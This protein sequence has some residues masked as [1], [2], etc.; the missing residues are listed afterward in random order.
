[1]LEAFEHWFGPYPFY[2]DGYKLVEAPYLGMEHQSA[3]TYG[4]GY[5]NGYRGHDLSGTGW[6][7]KFDYIIIHES[8]HEWFANNITYKDYADMWVHES[9]TTYSESLFLDFHYGKE[10]AAEYVIGQRAHIENDR[11]IIGI[12]NVNQTGSGD[13]YYKGANMLHMLRQIVN[14]DEKWRGIL[15]GLNQDFYHQTVTTAQIENYLTAQIGR[16]LKP[17][18]DQYLRD[19]RVPELSYRQDGKKLLYRWSNCVPEF[20]MPVKVTVA[21]KEIWLEPTTAWQELQVASKKASLEV[22]RNFYV[23]AAKAKSI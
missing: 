1:M 8:G 11:P 21:G 19:V 2:E 5:Q 23:T 14:N 9:F 15:R 10:A 7:K 12:Y 4:N 16:D 3:V 18:F 20:A 13:M 17:V 6:G 22:D